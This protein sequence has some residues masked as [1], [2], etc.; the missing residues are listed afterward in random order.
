M[1][2]L[3]A[4][5]SKRALFGI[6]L[7]APVGVLPVADA[8]V[9]DGGTLI[10]NVTVISPELVAP[11]AHAVV[12]MR[13]GKIAEIGTDI[14]AGAHANVIDG[15]RGLLIPGLID[16]HVHAAAGM[17]LIHHQLVNMTEFRRLPQ[18]VFDRQRYETSDAFAI[19]CAE[20][21]FRVGN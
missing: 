2:H 9:V 5:M 11:R 20:I 12:V 4:N 19:D 17:F 13:D 15:H 6:V 1:A 3:T 21:N 8:K 14:T 18:I 7:Y 16:S 10:K